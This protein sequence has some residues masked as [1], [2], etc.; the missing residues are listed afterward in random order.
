[1]NEKTK[2]KEIIL[3]T[4]G[5]LVSDLHIAAFGTVT[6]AWLHEQ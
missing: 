5:F 1:M 6:D 3:E 2:K 4:S